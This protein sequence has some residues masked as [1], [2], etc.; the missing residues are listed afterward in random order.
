MLIRQTWSSH[1]LLLTWVVVVVV[2]VVADREESEV[3]GF[4]TWSWLVE[5]DPF[6]QGGK[7]CFVEL[8]LSEQNIG[9]VNW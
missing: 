2:V 8:E 7:L 4:V 6:V 9:T 3:T 5:I 1:L